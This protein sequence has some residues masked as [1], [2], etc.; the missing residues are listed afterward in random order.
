MRYSQ[1]IIT[2]LFPFL[3]KSLEDEWELIKSKKSSL[4]SAERQQITQLC[5]ELENEGREV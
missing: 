2:V 3:N 5:L 1:E 4:C